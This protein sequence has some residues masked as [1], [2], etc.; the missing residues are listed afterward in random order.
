MAS[1]EPYKRLFRK[2]YKGYTEV[3]QNRASWKII[4]LSHV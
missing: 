1:V 2:R 3:K 4:I